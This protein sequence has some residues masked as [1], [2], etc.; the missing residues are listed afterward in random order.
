MLSWESWFQK[1]KKVREHSVRNFDLKRETYN[2][3]EVKT[4]IEVRAKRNFRK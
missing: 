3:V 2:G 4:G 1:Q